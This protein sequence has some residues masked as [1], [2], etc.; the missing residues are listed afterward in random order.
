MGGRR[1]GKGK[2]KGKKNGGKGGILCSCDFFL[3]KARLTL[4]VNPS[5][6]TTFAQTIRPSQRAINV[7]LQMTSN[8]W[9]NFHARL[10][11]RQ[12]DSLINYTLFYLKRKQVP[13]KQIAKGANF[14]S[15][16]GHLVGSLR[17][18]IPSSLRLFICMTPLRI[19]DL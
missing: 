14:R 8:C 4:T 18:R 5:Y 2:E 16:A 17:A 1:N 19:S 15:H 9:D 11:R 10:E 3:G 12:A 6:P 13:E 7:V